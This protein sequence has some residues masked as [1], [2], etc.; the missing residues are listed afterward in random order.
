[1]TYYFPIGAAFSTI[2]NN[3][4]Y[5]SL[6]TSAS[7]AVSQTISVSTASYALTSGSVPSN[8]TNGISRVE[9][10]CLSRSPVGDTGATGL[11]GRVGENVVTCPE[12]TVECSGLFESLSGAFTGYPNGLNGVLPSGSRYSKV[13]M[14]IPAGCDLVNVGCPDYLPVAFPAILPTP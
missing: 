14:Q 3:I 4:N 7:A 6:A 11:R 13:C 12:G 1:M 2:A 8:G 9:A 10:D 5:A